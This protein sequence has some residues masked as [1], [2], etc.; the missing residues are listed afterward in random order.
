VRLH[1]WEL[2]RQQ[3]R[4]GAHYRLPRASRILRPRS[5][6]GGLLALDRLAG[7]VVMPPDEPRPRIPAPQGQHKASG[8][9]T[10]ALVS[11]PAGSR[12]CTRSSASACGHRSCTSPGCYPHGAGP[13]GGMWPGSGSTQGRLPHWQR[14]DA[15]PGRMPGGSRRHDRHRDPTGRG[16]VVRPGDRVGRGASGGDRGG[17]AGGA[18]PGGAFSIHRSACPVVTAQEPDD[19]SRRRATRS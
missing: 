17:G 10:P 7:E 18:S 19:R 6:R 1:G 15:R 9:L 3:L 4:P 11:R 8:D 12:R 16:W 5:P 13:A 14:P 2:V